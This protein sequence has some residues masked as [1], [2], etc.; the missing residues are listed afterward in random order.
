MYNFSF[1]N[2]RHEAGMSMNNLPIIWIIDL[3]NCTNHL[4]MKGR[5]YM[6]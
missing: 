3:S 5:N 2:I 4:S 6:R 1:V